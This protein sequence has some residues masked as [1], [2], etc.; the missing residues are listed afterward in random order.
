MRIAHEARHVR[1]VPGI[2]PGSGFRLGIAA[3]LCGGC[4]ATGCAPSNTALRIIAKDEQIP[5][6]SPDRAGDWPFWPVSVQFLPLSRSVDS[7]AVGGRSLELFVECLD[8][9]GHTTKGAGH[10]LIELNCLTAVPPSTRLTIDLTDLDTN[11]ARW[12]EVTGSYRFDLA[13]P[14]ETP[15]AAGTDVDCRVILFAS[16]GRTPTATTRI[17]W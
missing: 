12:D 16:D 5:L 4:L 17:K 14:F 7:K 15:P 9:N 1:P 13:A 2:P 11:R 8:A 10:F 3:I 6:G